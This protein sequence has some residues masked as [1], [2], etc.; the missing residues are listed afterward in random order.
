MNL[1]RALAELRS[2]PETLQTPAQIVQAAQQDEAL[3]LEAVLT[4]CDVLGSVIGCLL[5]TSRCV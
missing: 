4:F 2:A 3:A 5:Y 1:Y